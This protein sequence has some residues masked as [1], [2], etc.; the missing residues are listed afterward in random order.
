M[1][2]IKPIAKK[3]SA[4]FISDVQSIIDLKTKP[5][6][7][8][9]MLEEVACKIAHIQHSLS[10]E[11]NQPSLYI[12]AADHGIAEEGVSL[13][14]QAV[15]EQMVLNFLSGGVAVNCFASQH[16]LDLHIVNAGVSCDFNI[17]NNKFINH[18][19]AKGTNNFLKTEAM[20]EVQCQLALKK[21]ADIV[22][23]KFAEGCN[24]IGF[25]E[26]GIANTTSAVRHYGITIRPLWFGLLRKRNRS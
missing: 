24:V 25:G 15:T 5:Q 3:L 4:S 17:K 13:F 1:F 16:Q 22:E 8:L 9:G 20:T 7:S 21:G 11:I 2:D 6:G 19:I 14:P 18:P 26:M 12:F 10:I 23:A